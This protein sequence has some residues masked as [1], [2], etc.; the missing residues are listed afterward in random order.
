[1]SIFWS[2]EG[3]TTPPTRKEGK[4]ESIKK[5]LFLCD[6]NVPECKKT[7]CYKS[8]GE[9]K[10]TSDIRHAINFENVSEYGTYYKIGHDIK[11]PRCNKEDK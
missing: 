7:H 6:G 4:L 2:K 8:G 11:E 10:C 9:C 3:K 5:I 1:M